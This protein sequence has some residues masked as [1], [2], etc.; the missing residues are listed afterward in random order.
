MIHNTAELDEL[1]SRPS[2]TTITSISRLD[3]DLLVLGAGGKM[4][5]SL[6]KMARRALEAS[7]K[8]NRVIAASRFSDRVVQQDLTDSGIETIQCDLLDQEAVLGL[9]DC[10]SALF[11][12]GQK[13]GTTANPEQTWAIN[14]IA[15][16][17]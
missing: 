9:P 10:A 4:G 17:T 12:A 13:F 16:L 14:T 11:L 5:P 6:A 7:G 1:L 8:A 15:Q 3:G 2:Q